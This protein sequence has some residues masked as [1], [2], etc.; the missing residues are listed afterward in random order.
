M[1]NAPVRLT[2]EEKEQLYK[3]IWFYINHPVLAVRDI[4][5][6]PIDAPHVR[7]AIREEW[8]NHHVI[9]LLS[10]G[11]MKTTLDAIMSILA[12]L[13]IPGI[14]ILILGPRF[15]QGRYTFEDAGIEPIVRCQM[16]VQDKTALFALNS[17][18]D[19]AKVITRGTDL[20]RIRFSNG[21]QIFTGPIG[22]TGDTVRGLRSNYTKLDEVKDFSDRAINKVIKPMS[23]VLQNPIGDA[24]TSLVN[25]FTYSGTIGYSDDYYSSLINEYQ[26]KMDP[27]SDLFDDDYTI[28]EF[29]FEDTFYLDS[30]ESITINSSNVDKLIKQNKV[31]FFYR[32]NLSEIIKDKESDTVD[33]EDWFAENKNR[34]LK[35]GDRFFPYQLINEVSNMEFTDQNDPNSKYKFPE[36]LS[37][38][39]GS[40]KDFAAFLEPILEC[41]QATIMGVDPARESDKTAI[42]IIRPGELHGDPF[43][44]IIYARTEKQMPIK[45]QAML[46][47]RLI[48]QFSVEAV[49]IDKK[50]NG[51][52]IMDELVDPDLT[53]LPGA[54]PIVDPEFDENQR[55][56]AES[57]NGIP[58]LNMVN[59]TVELNTNT[60]TRLRAAFQKKTFL[61]PKPFPI[62][63]DQELERVHRDIQAL[64]GQ[65]RKIK[66]KPIGQGLKFYMPERKSADESLE[67]GYKDLFS[68]LL[69]AFHGL[70]LK[71]RPDDD[72]SRGNLGLLSVMRP[73]VVRRRR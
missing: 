57:G 5:G 6:L 51:V 43:N 39:G 16:G 69:Y 53:K 40:K 27:D 42:V 10:R 3:V 52:S 9:K 24:D 72:T 61:L 59:P 28:I 11:M 41:D 71:V 20:W 35:L 63:G 30:T 17:C 37:L 44:H 4:L 12:A 2:E 50:G 58:I 1:S 68:A 73:I 55:Q 23:N 22:Q 45:E 36:E 47:R 65:L 48:D 26:E 15:R 34:P 13:L 7:I 49:Y 38:L 62:Q 14:K 21:S 67:R 56:L 29:N 70:L 18:V 54:I 33:S 25:R 66:A 19:K 64:R 60:A 8:N 46:I 32:I 31:K